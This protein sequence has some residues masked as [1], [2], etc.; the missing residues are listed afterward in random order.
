MIK[1]LMTTLTAT[2]FLVLAGCILRDPLVYVVR[3]RC[4]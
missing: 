3:H 2:M 1:T 4:F